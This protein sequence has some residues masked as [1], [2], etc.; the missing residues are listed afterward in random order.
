MHPDDKNLKKDVKE[1]RVR[2][3]FSDN[4]HRSGMFSKENNGK[5]AYDAAN[6]DF[7]AKSKSSHTSIPKS[8]IPAFLVCIVM[9]LFKGAEYLISVGTFNKQNTYLLLIVMQFFVYVIPCAFF[10]AIRN[11]KFKGGLSNYNLRPFSP[12]MFGFVFVSY[13][14][15]HWEA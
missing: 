5:D 11:H 3:S 1:T 7:K 9:V 10:S 4:S 6:P 15:L 8:G 2:T 14:C 13:L 12:K